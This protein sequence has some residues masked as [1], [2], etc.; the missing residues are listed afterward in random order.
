MLFKNICKNYKPISESL[1]S[2]PLVVYRPHTVS[3]GVQVNGGRTASGCGREANGPAAPEV[4]AGYFPHQPVN[5]YTN[6]LYLA[7][8][9]ESPWT[10]YPQDRSLSFS[11][12]RKVLIWCL[13]VLRS[14]CKLGRGVA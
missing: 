14:Y 11:S 4:T 7:T 9:P 12:I 3:A 5:F 8:A 10:F 1:H 6:S 13:G 2:Q